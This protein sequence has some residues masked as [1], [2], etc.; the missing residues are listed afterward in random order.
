LRHGHLHR[1]PSLL[2]NLQHDTLDTGENRLP[3]ITIK[4]AKTSNLH[5]G[6]GY[7]NSYRNTNTNPVEEYMVLPNQSWGCFTASACDI[8]PIF[9]AKKKSN[10]WFHKFYCRLWTTKRYAKD[11]KLTPN[12]LP[13]IKYKVDG[14][15]TRDGSSETPGRDHCN[16]RWWETGF[17]AGIEDRKGNLFNF[18]SRS[19]LSDSFYCVYALHVAGQL[20]IQAIACA[21]QRAPCRN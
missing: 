15:L 1:D 12:I 8:V 17:W 19:K 2:L 11:K 9:R 14:V 20:L 4:A 7:L 18:N 10:C 6:E 21:H 5:E 13:M 16:S 3:E